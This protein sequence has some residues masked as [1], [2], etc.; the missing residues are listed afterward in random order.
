MNYVP[1]GIVLDGSYMR[2]L[3]GDPA[4]GRDP[5]ET[6]RMAV[7]L[8]AGRRCHPVIV[9]TAMEAGVTYEWRTL[10]PAFVT[11]VGWT[12]LACGTGYITLTCDGDTYDCV[13]PVAVGGTARSDARWLHV[14]DAKTVAANGSWRCLEPGDAAVPTEAGFTLTC[15]GTVKV[16]AVQMRPLPRTTA[17]T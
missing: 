5:M 17:L 9:G 11:H 15:S 12:I 2:P 14:S 10:V 1:N 4:A 6:D 3:N 16:Y 7:H 13:V 8:A